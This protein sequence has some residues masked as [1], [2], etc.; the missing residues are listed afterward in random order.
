MNSPSK[1]TEADVRNF[2]AS[3]DLQYQKIQL[4]F[5]LFTPGEAREAT[6]E[7]IFGGDLRGKSVLDVGS[8]L[9]Y[10]PLQALARGAKRAVGWEIDPRRRAQARAIAEIVGAQAEYRPV[11][12]ESEIPREQFD[13]VIC[14]NVLHHMLDP[15]AVLDKL[16]A[17]ARERLV[18]EVPSFGGYDGKKMGL[19][20][21]QRRLL[22]RHPVALVGRGG[23]SKPYHRQKKYYLSK[24][25]IENIL[26]YQ[27]NHFARLEIRDSDFKDRFL[28]IA[29][30]RRIG[31]LLIVAGMKS[32]GKS[33]LIQQLRENRL[34]HIADRLGVSD[35]GRF[36]VT[37][38]TRLRSFDKPHV[39]NLI[40]H[41]NVHRP[42]FR[43][44][45]SPG[46]DEAL[47]VLD[48]ADRV[49]AITI[50]TG[51]EQV[52]DQIRRKEE[53]TV[54]NMRSIRRLNALFGRGLLGRLFARAFS[55]R[56]RNRAL[57]RH[58]GRHNRLIEVCRNHKADFVRFYRGWFEF[59]AERLPES[60]AHV[61]VKAEPGKRFPILE[62]W[63]AEAAEIEAGGRTEQR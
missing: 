11:D 21:W 33:T 22:A 28:V 46:R 54:S 12:I 62:D 4:P 63:E 60:G 24:T 31:H 18:L 47:H 36:E 43:S 2:L 3:E 26:M 35:F 8:F 40:F 13:I 23:N 20:W 41:Y 19:A 7:A 17:L 37:D 6:C 53:A 34:P 45:K 51:P 38:A 32:G 44:A 61:V 16:S 9:G 5:G 59:C 10:F 57:R 55:N 27:R 42:Y 39:S 50:W 15:I 25:A 56:L 48:G 30:K 52:I 49:S 1:W 29:E 58:M 14:L